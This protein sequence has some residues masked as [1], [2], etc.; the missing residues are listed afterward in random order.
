MLSSD[1]QVLLLLCSHLGLNSNPKFKPLNLKEWNKIASLLNTS[2]LRPDVLLNWSEK[3]L[4]HNL[5]ITS[6]EAQRI[7]YL[8]NR[9]GNLAIELERLESIGIHVL[10]RAD[11][12]YP[13]L[14]RQRLKTGAPTVL[15]YS[16]DNALL[17]QPGL[18]IVG[19]RNLDDIGQENASTVGNICGNSGMVLYSGG[20]K[21][22]DR[23]SMDAALDARGTAVAILANSLEQAIKNPKHRSAIQRGDLCLVTPYSPNSGFSV[24]AA[25]GRNRL[26]YA[27][28][29]YALIIASDAG[30]GGTWAGATEALK[31]NWIPIFV[32]KYDS[33]PDGNR[34]LL[35]KG[36]LPFPYPFTENISELQTWLDKSSQKTSKPIFQDT[37]FSI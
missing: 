4:I 26:I 31:F 34:Q 27:L 22:V 3:D 18:A 33:M 10:T 17:G 15:F 36:A 5:N 19:S 23:I 21:G 30:K 6:D 8:I 20:A 35:S 9:S 1:S 13:G 2:D 12:E 37:L 32:L 16:G 24:G 7:D 11:K 29:K 14:Y 25:M 28:A